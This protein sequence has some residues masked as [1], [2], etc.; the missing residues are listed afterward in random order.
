MRE[1]YM[2][3]GLHPNV[4]GHKLYGNYI[5]QEIIKIKKR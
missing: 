5:Y 2:P 4:A 1:K 3:D